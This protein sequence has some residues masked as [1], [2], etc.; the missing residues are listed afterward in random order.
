M[1]GFAPFATTIMSVL[2][3]VNGLPEHV[4]DLI[5]NELGADLE[6]ELVGTLL[7]IWTQSRRWD[8]AELAIYAITLSVVR[9]GLGLLDFDEREI[10]GG[11]VNLLQELF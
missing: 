3:P 11:G 10:I 6:G 4:R 9:G 2:V 8:V 5:G 1:S 7:H